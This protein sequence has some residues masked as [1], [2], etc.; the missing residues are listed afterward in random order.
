MRSVPIRY[1]LAQEFL[2]GSQLHAELELMAN[3]RACYEGLVETHCYV[4]FR[5]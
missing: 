3:V 4:L 1:V 5:G 2:V